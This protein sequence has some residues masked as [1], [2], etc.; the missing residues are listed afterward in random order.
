MI[1]HDYPRHALSLPL[2]WTIVVPV[3]GDARA[4]RRQLD[5]LLEAGSRRLAGN[6]V[7]QLRHDADGVWYIQYGLTGPGL[8]VTGKWLVASFSPYAVRQ[9]VV[10]LSPESGRQLE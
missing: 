4:L 8:V 3:T 7:L 9:N 2:A 6:S 1:I 5:R 10:H